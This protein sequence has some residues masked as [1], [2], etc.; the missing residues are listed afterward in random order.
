MALAAWFLD[1]AS[2]A[3]TV[4]TC[5]RDLEKSTRSDD[6]AA[7]AATR[8]CDRMR[9]LLRARTF[10]YI[11][12]VQLPNLDLFLAAPGSFFQ[13]DLHV[14]AQVRPALASRTVGLAAAKEMLEDSASSA[15]G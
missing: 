2:G 3:L 5:L 11:A 14:V 12:R 15:T 13:G 8:T 7:P 1:D 9:S 6:L 4:R 10:A